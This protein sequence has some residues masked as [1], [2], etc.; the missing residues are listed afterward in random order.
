MQ[1]RRSSTVRDVVAVARTVQHRHNAASDRIGAI[2][3]SLALD[4]R[5]LLTLRID[6]ELAWEDVARVMIEAEAPDA[7]ALAREVE[8]LRERFAELKSELRE[9][10]QHAEGSD[11]IDGSASTTDRPPANTPE[12]VGTVIG[13]YRILEVLD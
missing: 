8:R 3:D 6:R 9:R 10:V 1:F 7:A 2:R 13:S 5:I 4:D 12:I 11:P